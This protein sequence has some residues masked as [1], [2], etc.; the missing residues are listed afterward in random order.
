MLIRQKSEIYIPKTLNGDR[1]A[2]WYESKLNQRNI[3]Y[4]KRED[5]SYI[6]ISHDITW[7]E[8]PNDF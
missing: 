2:Q 5:L 6:I 4:L 8:N 7:T 1:Y 3:S